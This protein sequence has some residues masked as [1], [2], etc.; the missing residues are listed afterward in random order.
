MHDRKK[1][2]EKEKL[3]YISFG[4]ITNEMHANLDP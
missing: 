1:V 2:K 3:K 4:A